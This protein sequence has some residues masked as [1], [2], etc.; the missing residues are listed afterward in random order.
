MRRKHIHE[1]SMNPTPDQITV[2]SH[3]WLPCCRNVIIV[4]P[5]SFLDRLRSK[6]K[7]A[8]LNIN[9]K[10]LRVAAHTHAWNVI[11][12][13]R[14]LDTSKTSGGFLG[15]YLPERVQCDALAECFYG[16]PEA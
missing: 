7:F 1:H 8:L 9:Q 16:E 10:E 5:I 14:S 4:P 3:S 12:D 11:D 6:S 15:W 2:H 13:A